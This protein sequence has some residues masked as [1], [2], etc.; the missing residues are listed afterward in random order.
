[1]YNENRKAAKKKAAERP[2]GMNHMHLLCISFC[3]L[4][5]GAGVTLQA[6][7]SP[8]ATSA[9]TPQV[10]F[11]QEE[12]RL[13]VFINGKQAATYVYRDKNISR[14]FFANVYTPTGIKVTRN[15]PPV[16]DKDSDDHATYHPGIWMAFG[17]INGSDYWRN[18]SAVVH[19]QFIDPPKGGPGKGRFSVENLFLRKKDRSDVLCRERCRLTFIVRPGGCLIL[20]DAKI[21]AGSSA[22]AFGRQEESGLGVRVATPITVRSGGRILNSEGRLNEKHVW[23]RLA[24]WCDYSGKIKGTPCGITVFCHPENRRRNWF[25]VRDYGLLTANPSGAITARRGDT[26]KLIVKA[27]DTLHLRYGIFIHSAKERS[28]KELDSTYKTYVQLS[29]INSGS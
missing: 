12:G 25:H 14:P 29:G 18:R 6:E 8:A 16:A 2:Q 15:H 20:W 24:S 4:V 22:L 28:K 1:M 19:N 10:T 27:G 21:T 11:K 23:G 3:S 13:Q 7:T 26:K 9:D 5:L 17:D